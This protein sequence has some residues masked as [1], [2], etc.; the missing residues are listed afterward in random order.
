M[1]FLRSW[2]PDYVAALLIAPHRGGSGHGYVCP[3]GGILAKDLP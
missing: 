2:I 1:F 3:W